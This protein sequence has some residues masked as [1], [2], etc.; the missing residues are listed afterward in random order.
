MSINTDVDAVDR[1]D[2]HLVID[3]GSPEVPGQQLLGAFTN[4]VAAENR[5]ADWMNRGGAEERARPVIVSFPL[6]RA[7]TVAYPFTEDSTWP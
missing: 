3:L 6:D 1:V 4:R 2:L 5:L 7:I